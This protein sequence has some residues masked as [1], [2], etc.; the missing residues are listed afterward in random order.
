ML[1]LG[2]GGIY[3]YTIN[4]VS[5][6]SQTLAYQ[7][8]FILLKL[9]ILNTISYRE[10]PY[11]FEHKGKH[12][13]GISKSWHVDV[14]GDNARKYAQMTGLLYDGG[15]KTT[16]MF[17][18]VTNNYILIPLRS[19]DKVPYTGLVYDVVDVGNTACFLT[20]VGIVHNCMSKHLGTAKILTREALQRAEKG[21]PRE[22]VLEKIR[23]AYEELMGA[24][25]DS[26][27]LEDER[28]RQLN[29]LIRDTRKWFFDTGVIVEP[30]KNKIVEALGRVSKL[31]DEVYSEY[32]KRKARLKEFIG[33]AKERLE[34]LEAKISAESTNP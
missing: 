16:G 32:E 19:I 25:D 9:G 1:T 11:E 15:G 2:D 7:I 29:A 21:E 8:R 23:G 30:D 18:H 17:G 31:N 14:S 5:T 22:A 12:T 26:L 10:E 4:V 6:T 3:K 24:E 33:K 20:H 13:R 28:V 34:Q 27:S